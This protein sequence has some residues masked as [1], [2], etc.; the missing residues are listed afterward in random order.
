MYTG[1]YSSLHLINVN[2]LKENLS[3]G[4]FLTVFPGKML[5]QF[6]GHADISSSKTC[7]GIINFQLFLTLHLKHESEMVLSTITENTPIFFTLSKT[8]AQHGGCGRYLP[9]IFYHLHFDCPPCFR[10]HR[11]SGGVCLIFDR[12]GARGGYSALDEIVISTWAI[13]SLPER[14]FHMPPDPP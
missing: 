8:I 3:N 9:H 7:Y 12:K 4:I 1:C 2:Y 5:F 6:I 11:S 14:S 13:S 10:D